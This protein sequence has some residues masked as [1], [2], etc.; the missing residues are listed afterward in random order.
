M[1]VDYN[2]LKPPANKLLAALPASDYERLLPHMKHV[3]LPFNQIIYEPGEPITHIYFPHHSV[4]SIVTS[5]EDGSTVEAGLVSS[6]GMVGITVILGGDTTT[7]RALVQIGDGGTQINADVLKTEFNRGGALQSLLLRYVQAQYTELGQGLACN[8]LHTIE[9]RLARWLLTVTDRLESKDFLLTQEFIAQMLG[10][11][12][13]G[14]TVAA[15]TLSQAG[16]ISYNRGRIKI[17]NRGIL[18]ETSCECYQVIKDE[19]A[20][21]LDNSP[22]DNSE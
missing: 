13:S 17:L 4:I 19:F 14:V 8:R 21:L 18:E 3:P 11:R 7:T 22:G 1:S 10:V 9:E 16:I 6:E 2:T 20:R 5:M 12:R 15:S